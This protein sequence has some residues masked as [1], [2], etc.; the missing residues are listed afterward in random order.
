AQ[1]LPPRMYGRSHR[2]VELLQS[3]CLRS[4]LDRSR[5][6]RSDRQ[7]R[8]ALDDGRAEREE[9]RGRTDTDDGQKDLARTRER[10]LSAAHLRESFR[11]KGC[12]TRPRVHTFLARCIPRIARRQT[13]AVRPP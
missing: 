13:L 1:I 9:Q 7:Y 10:E 12:R 4:W 2:Q 11:R 6:R 5:Y 3:G 8:D